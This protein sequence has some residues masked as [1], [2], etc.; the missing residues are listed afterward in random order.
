MNM[1]AA[2]II[3]V[4]GIVLLLFGV[5][6][7]DSVSNAFSKFFTGQ[8]TDRTVLLILGGSVLLVIGLVGCMRYRQG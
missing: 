1:F 4:A 5:V 7:S 2:L 6:A 3:L 8:F